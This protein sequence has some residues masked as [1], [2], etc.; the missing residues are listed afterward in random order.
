MQS[1]CIFRFDENLP[2]LNLKNGMKREYFFISS[3]FRIST[4]VG[5]EKYAILLRQIQRSEEAA[6]H[7]E[8][9]RVIRA[10][11]TS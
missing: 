6:Q 3:L 5:L 11:R 9:V 2:L 1:L 10:T 4:T 8:R 7:E